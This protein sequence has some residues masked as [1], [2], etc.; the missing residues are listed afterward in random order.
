MVPNKLERTKPLEVIVVVPSLCSTTEKLPEELILTVLPVSRLVA[1]PTN[2]PA[3]KI[4]PSL[5]MKKFWMSGA[6][7]WMMTGKLH[8][9]ASVSGPCTTRSLNGCVAPAVP[10]RTSAL[11][12]RASYDPR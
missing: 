5:K 12:V 9:S 11:N 7:G 8:V 1:V 6:V 10:A 3:P 4:S 2:G